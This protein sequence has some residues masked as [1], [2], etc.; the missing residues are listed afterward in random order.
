[1]LKM[2]LWD[3]LKALEML[4][5]HFGL[6]VDR[7]EHTG[8]SGGPMTVEAVRR[9]PDEELEHALLAFVAKALPAAPS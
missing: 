3:K 7:T 8:R 5:K 4:G 6:F 2:K 9:M 1:M